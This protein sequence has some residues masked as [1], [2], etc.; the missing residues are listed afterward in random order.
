MIYRSDVLFFRFVAISFSVA[1]YVERGY[2]A[3]NTGQGNTIASV[4]A[5]RSPNSSSRLLWISDP[6]P[7]D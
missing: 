1:Q 4:P 6:D 5:E 2:L 7:M 3:D